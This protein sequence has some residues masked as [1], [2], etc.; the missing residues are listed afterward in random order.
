M[1]LG[2]NLVTLDVNI[3][4][5]YLWGRQAVNQREPNS[6]GIP[7]NLKS[8]QNWITRL[9]F[10]QHAKINFHRKISLLPVTPT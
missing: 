8:K 5:C 3:K 7:P 6:T 1:F 2:D 4:W 9:I 10:Y